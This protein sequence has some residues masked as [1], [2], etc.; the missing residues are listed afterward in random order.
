MI[1]NI[2]ENMQN[3]KNITIKPAD[4]NL[5]LV[6]LPTLEYI[7]LCNIILNDGIILYEIDS[8]ISLNSKTTCNRCL[9]T[10]YVSNYAD[11]NCKIKKV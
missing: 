8:D 6:V 10:F 11:G 2:I 4:K 1:N 9:T 7:K 5:G 3:N